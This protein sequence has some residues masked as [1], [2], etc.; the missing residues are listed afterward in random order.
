M[1]MGR[2]M[3]R[4]IRIPGSGGRVDGGRGLTGPPPDNRLIGKNEGACAA[5]VHDRRIRFELS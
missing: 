5:R 3:N 2:I 4:R 1:D